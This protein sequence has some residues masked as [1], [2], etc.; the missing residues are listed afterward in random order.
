M[1]GLLVLVTALLVVCVAG[2][3][4]SRRRNAAL[5]HRAQHDALT[6][7]A[8]RSVLS[9]RLDRE[10]RQNSVGTAVLVLDLNRFKEVNDT[11]GHHIGDALLRVVA[12]RL[13]SALPDAD[14]VARLGGDEF[15]VLLR[16]LDQPAAVAGDRA[17]A[18]VAVLHDPVRLEDALIS[19]RASVGIAL[20]G[21]GVDGA[22]LLRQADT[23]MY[24]AKTS[25]THVTLYGPHLDQGRSERLQL[26]ADL[27][28]ALE[29]DEFVL[30]Y[31][32]KLAVGELLL[33]DGGRSA[34]D[35]VSCV[36]ALVRW[37]H[38]RLGL[39]APEAF[40]P[41][42][43]ASGLVEPLTR[44]VLGKALAQLQAWDSAGLHMRV[45]VNLPARSIAGA[46]LPAVVDEQ[47][48]RTGVSADRLTLELTEASV[49][50]DPERN[51]PVLH[52]LT[53]L[54]VELSLDDF[55][56]GYSSLSYLQRMPV[57][58]VKIDKSFVLGLREP[59]AR[60]ASEQLIRSIVNLAHGLGLRVVAEGVED[61][62]VLTDLLD[63]QVDAVQGYLVGRPVPAAELFDAPQG[64]RTVPPPRD[65]PE[66][67][68][69]EGP[70]RR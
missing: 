19:T 42:A 53:G 16:G 63:M 1:T 51:L 39:L 5:R 60:A 14:V 31:Q 52:E 23:A 49:M 27:Q 46:A 45:A 10:L 17:R 9:E 48:R 37:Q 41:L 3:C 2:L 36:E 65:L 7:L 70:A 29:R 26:L 69:A 11:L 13:V 8:N 25:G 32:P 54:G 66:R 57:S 58:E 18:V 33:L 20:G 4:V 61:D 56:T 34:V 67:R 62:S 12:K 24:V 50:D 64:R 6:G 38:P 15:A 44:I 47:L 30:R 59:D 22:D 55:G 40:L 28:Q 43:D 35:S 21:P 68:V